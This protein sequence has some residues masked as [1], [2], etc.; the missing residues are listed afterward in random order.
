MKKKKKQLTELVEKR[1]NAWGCLRMGADVLII[2]SLSVSE[3]QK[4]KTQE[5]NF[6]VLI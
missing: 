5:K 4:H 3:K 6:H 1:N 2:F